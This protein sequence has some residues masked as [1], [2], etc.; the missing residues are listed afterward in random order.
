MKDKKIKDFLLLYNDSFPID[1]CINLYQFDDDS[2]KKILKMLKDQDIADMLKVGEDNFR[3]S[4][5]KLLNSNQLIQVFQGMK[6]D[7]IVDLIGLL[8]VS[9]RKKIFAE[10]ESSGLNSVKELLGYKSDVAGGIMTTEYITLD[11]NMT[12][13]EAFLNVC[14]IAPKSEVIE[15]MYITN[16]ENKL[17][18]KINIRDLLVPDRSSKLISI[19]D[20]KVLSITPEIDQEEVARIVSKYDLIAIPVVNDENIVLGV[21]TLDDIIDVIY[22][23]QSEDLLN[24]GGV[25]QSDTVKVKVVPSIGQRLP[26]LFVNLATVFFAA[27]VVSTF[28]GEIERFIALAMA[29]PIIAGMGGN[30]GNQVLAMTIRDLTFDNY[31]LGGKLYRKVLKEIIVGFVNGIILGAAAGV[32]IYIKYERIMLSLIVCVA[33]ICN[34][35]I[36]NIA[37]LLIPTLLKKMKRD[38]AVGSSILVTAITDSFGFFI[39]LSLAKWLIKY[40]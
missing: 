30:S 6:T 33:M 22:Q 12:L 1:N 13:E 38:P 40:I 3:K 2:I 27:F 9:K 16:E 36:A 14:R 15:E 10:I 8:K 11:E 4:I 17:I 28:E 32:I 37:G 25:A 35:I 23:E 26:W 19:I 18:G 21:I 20:K 29:M 34:F 7:D 5:L 39:L 24:I 31:N